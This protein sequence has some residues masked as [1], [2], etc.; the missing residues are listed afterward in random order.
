MTGL[1]VLLA[2]PAPQAVAWALLHF[3]WQGALIAGALALVLRLG[4]RWTPDVR[5]L[6]ACLALL[7]LLAV[8]VLTAIGIGRRLAAP[9]L[10]AEP[11]LLRSAAPVPLDGAAAD[12]SAVAPSVSLLAGARPAIRAAVAPLV[13]WI[14]LFWLAG[15]A[16][17]TARALRERLLV[18]WLRRQGE[19]AGATL[20]R[21]LDRLAGLSRLARRIELRVSDVVRVPSAIGWLRPVILLPPALLLQLTPAQLEL[22]LAHELAHIRRNDYA[23]NLLQTVLETLLFFHPAVW[24]VSRRVRIEREHAC[25]RFAVQLTGDPVAYARALTDVAALGLPPAAAPVMALTG[26][27]GVSLMERIHR[28]LE[29]QGPARRTRRPSAG[30][31][32]SALAVVA[33]LALSRS[34][35]AQDPV[36]AAAG[37]AER[38]RQ[39][40]EIVERANQL[41]TRA[42]A[43]LRRAAGD[44]SALTRAAAAKVLGE[45]AEPADGPR[46]VALLGDSSALVRKEAAVA[47]GIMG[48]TPAR[49][50]LAEALGD[51]D[52]GVREQAAYALAIIGRDHAEDTERLIRL[53]RDPEA[54]V[55]AGVA[56]ALG[57]L[58]DPR[59]VDALTALLRD[60]VESVRN[61]A[62]HSLSRLAGGTTGNPNFNFD[63]DPDRDANPNYNR[64]PRPDSAR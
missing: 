59:V 9:E 18:G 6:A 24:W 53:A 26:P 58:G 1:E 25:D 47:L 48:H 5:H 41:R 50:R 62:R 33:A 40:I 10:A 46:L 39:R 28:I 32:A 7:A 36:D 15:V 35:I 54:S 45:T 3:L 16:V 57:V 64:N 49:P 20:Q 12:A 60:P 51:R 43:E 44:P 27:K 2:Q 13:P 8:P 63:F 52:A 34:A 38:A 21:S 4:R 61:A 37:D 56:R 23:V 22:I 55:R 29:S 19:R 30:I 31:A 42:P 17:L 14:L 11:L